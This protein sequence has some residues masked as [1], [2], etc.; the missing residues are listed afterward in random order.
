MLKAVERILVLF[1]VASASGC[2]AKKRAP[3]WPVQG[4]IVYVA[5]RLVPLWKSGEI[6]SR[7]Q[8]TDS[9]VQ[10]IP[11]DRMRTITSYPPCQALEV[12]KVTFES[13]HLW[14]MEDGQVFK[15]TGKWESLVHDT[16]E[17]CLEQIEPGLLHEGYE[18]TP[19]DPPTM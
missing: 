18:A 19:Q 13:L 3:G 16:R 11:L 14:H 5:E 15:M 17:E 1:L 4:K 12:T 8:G 9:G 7:E 2:A 6:H 10:Q